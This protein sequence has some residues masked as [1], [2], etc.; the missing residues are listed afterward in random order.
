[1]ERRGIAQI[2][3]GDAVEWVSAIIPAQ[4]G[5]K[6][7]EPGKNAKGRDR[8][9]AEDIIAWAVVFEDCGVE[10]ITCD[11]PVRDREYVLLEP[12]GQV[13]LPGVARW[14]NLDEF[15]AHLTRTGGKI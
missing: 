6:I 13:V 4:P 2:G 5:W 14:D 8:L 9:C 7:V 10:P 12:G 15:R 1:M 3:R 11:G